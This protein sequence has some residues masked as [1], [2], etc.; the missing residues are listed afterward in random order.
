MEEGRERCRRRFRLKCRLEEHKKRTNY[1]KITEIRKKNIFCALTFYWR[2]QA[3][4]H[5]LSHTRIRL[6]T[7]ILLLF[8]LTFFAILYVFM[9]EK[10]RRTREK[11]KT[12]K[13]KRERKSQLSRHSPSENRSFER[14]RERERHYY[15]H[16]IFILSGEFLLG[17]TSIIYDCGSFRHLC[18]LLLFFPA[19]NTQLLLYSWMV[20]C[21]INVLKSA[22][23][24][25]HDIKRKQQKAK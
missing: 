2:A 20:P 6:P 24:I 11:H 22:N 8:L 13:W 23:I 18:R 12:L 3:L 17:T 16:H 19:H 9:W 7:S 1:A 4:A 10:E 21:K 25:Q 14:D 5:S 15:E